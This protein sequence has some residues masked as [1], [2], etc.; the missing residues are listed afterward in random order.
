ML[1]S[2]TLGAVI[3]GQNF[4]PGPASG[5]PET[6]VIKFVGDFNA[7]TFTAAASPATG[8]FPGYILVA[9]VNGDGN[10]GLVVAHYQDG[11]LTVLLGNGDGTFTAAASGL[12][13]PENI[14][15]IGTADFNGDG[16]ADLILSGNIYDSPNDLVVLLG[17]GDGTFTMGTAP[18][19]TGYAVGAAIAD[20]NGDGKPDI[21]L[22][23]EIMDGTES[24]QLAI[25]LGK[26]DGTFTTT[27][28]LLTGYQYAIAAADFNGDGKPDL[29]FSDTVNN[30]VYLLTGNGDGTFTTSGTFASFATFALS[31]ADFNGDGAPDLATLQYPQQTVGESLAIGLAATRVATATVTGISLP[32]SPKTQIIKASYP[33]DSYYAAS[34]SAGDTMSAVTETL[35]PA[36]L[37]F[38]AT[39]AG[40][41]SN[42]QTVTF[43]N[44]GTVTLQVTSF[45]QPSGGSFGIRNQTCGKTLLAGAACTFDVVFKP[46]VC[47]AL[48]DHVA[49]LD[50][51]A[52]STQ[53]VTLNGVG[54]AAEIRFST[55][56]LTFS[57][58]P[59]GSTSSYQ[60]VWVYSTGNEPLTIRSIAVT[61]STDPYA[62]GIRD[63]TCGTTLAAGAT[64]RFKV[65]F[66]PD[67]SGV[68]TAAIS[69]DDY[70]GTWQ[71]QIPIEGTAN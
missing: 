34:L 51:A 42:Y 58:V 2:G 53:Y 66:R 55:T 23:T 16:K 8:N 63:Q 60:Q 14:S 38:P 17:N 52:S 27:N 35:L 61:N 48:E 10:L 47:C 39:Y 26:G 64:C 15:F 59:V 57:D 18:V 32:S 21:A 29:A 40:D 41:S 46:R 11:P 43:T 3:N 45:E 36:A 44:T 25:L 13:V 50:N 9:D 4:T 12:T 7:G 62:W 20:F 6:A 54:K 31:A 28:T 33:G 37:N 69:I 71:Q 49:I 1:A 56:G 65:A 22:T 70:V 19:L 67:H 68:S 30:L 5:I 24:G